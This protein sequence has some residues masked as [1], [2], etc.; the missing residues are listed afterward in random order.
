MK[1]QVTFNGEYI[2]SLIEK[3]GY[4]LPQG[5]AY[6]RDGARAIMD[7]CEENGGILATDG[8]RYS[9]EKFERVRPEEFDRVHK[10]G[11]QIATGY[12]IKTPMCDKDWVIN[13]E[14]M[15]HGGHAFIDMDDYGG[16]DI[17]RNSWKKWGIRKH[18]VPTGN[19]WISKEYRAK[20][21]QSFIL[22]GPKRVK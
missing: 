8:R 12:K 1:K 19:F 14:G 20:L 3:W 16:M 10:K 11:Y 7:E 9:F 5:G 13:M 17:G 22:I 21:F 6:L 18:G 2:W 4:A 15:D